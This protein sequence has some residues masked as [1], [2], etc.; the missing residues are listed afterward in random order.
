MG[1]IEKFLAKPQDVVIAGETFSLTPFTVGDMALLNRM[2]SKDVNEQAQAIQ[3]AVFKVIKQIDSEAT[4]EQ[5]NKV[6]M[7]YLQQIMEAIAKINSID[8]DDAK[9]AALEKIRKAQEGK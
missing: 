1:K 2:G 4:Q 9:K 3:E 7:E 5:A 6:S 8:M